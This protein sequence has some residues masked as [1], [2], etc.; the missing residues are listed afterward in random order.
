LGRAAVEVGR[1]GKTF[2][3]MYVHVQEIVDCP[4][5][6]QCGRSGSSS[7]LDGSSDLLWCRRLPL[8]PEAAGGRGKEGRRRGKSR[9]PDPDHQMLDALRRDAIRNQHH[10]SW[11]HG[12]LLIILFPE[13]NRRTAVQAVSLESLVEAEVIPWMVFRL[14]KVQ[15]AMSN[16]CCVCPAI[17]PHTSH[18]EP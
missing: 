13:S 2:W 3:W 7:N 5:P 6:V 4:V 1:R 11:T 15:C 16:L 8:S 14:P 17:L 18:P 12:P 10:H 9:G